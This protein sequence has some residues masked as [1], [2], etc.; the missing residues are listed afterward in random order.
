[1]QLRSSKDSLLFEVANFWK[2]VR[3]AC[4][5]SGAYDNGSL[6]LL[7]M[8]PGSALLIEAAASYIADR[9]TAS[10]QKIGHMQISVL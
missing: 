1:M 10:L 8:S 6:L 7:A 9:V 5:S 2:D 4:T 3:A